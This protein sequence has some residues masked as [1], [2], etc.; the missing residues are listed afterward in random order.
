MKRVVLVVILAV[1]VLSSNYSYGQVLVPWQGSNGKW[2][3]M[4]EGTDRLIIHCKYDL[5]YG[6]TEGLAMVCYGGKC[7]FIDKDDNLVIPLKYDEPIQHF[8]EGLA[9]VTVNSKTGFIDKTDKVVIPI[10][11]DHVSGFVKGT[12]FV[13]GFS[14][15][16][17]DGRYGFI[18]QTGTEVVPVKYKSPVKARQ[19][20]LK[21]TRKAS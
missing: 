7:G 13:E 12:T 16:G 14:M 20:L 9:M 1:F 19:K 11:Y 15:V 5:V 21:G 17:L 4:D 3:F 6:F 2:G 8:S 18:D 10:K